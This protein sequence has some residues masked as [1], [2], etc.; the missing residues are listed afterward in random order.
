MGFC[1]FHNLSRGGHYPYS[2][3]LLLPFRLR[4]FCSV[5][6][7]Q[8]TVGRASLRRR[9]TGLTAR[10]YRGK[11]PFHRPTLRVLCSVCRR[12]C[13]HCC[14][15]AALSSR[16]KVRSGLGSLVFVPAEQADAN[17][18]QSVL[19]RGGLL[20]PLPSLD[21]DFLRVVVQLSD[22]KGGK[23]PTLPG[24]VHVYI[25]V[26]MMSS[27]GSRPP[28]STDKAPTAT[29]CIHHSSSG[30]FHLSTAYRVCIEHTLLGTL[31]SSGETQPVHPP[32]Y[33]SNPLDTAVQAPE[34]QHTLSDQC[35]SISVRMANYSNAGDYDLVADSGGCCPSC[36]R[37]PDL[38]VH[39]YCIPCA[40]NPSCPRSSSSYSSSYTSSSRH[41]TWSSSS[42]SVPRRAHQETAAGTSRAFER[43]PDSK[44]PS[45]ASKRSG[46]KR[47]SA[48][49]STAKDSSGGAEKHRASKSRAEE[50]K[51]SRKGAAVA[52]RGPK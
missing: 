17:P 8:A 24:S 12:H 6:R 42:A 22:T 36:C 16:P 15:S 14:C 45:Q 49:T 29:T 23:G 38:G 50:T 40:S 26:Y 30:H 5:S 3:T 47:H 25:R 39:D 10:T 43:K 35:E 21:S 18:D 52:G 44:V 31:I 48:E 34:C 32:T 37:A 51:G 9:E 1:P 46:Q 19:Y 2:N 20:C 7:R 33:K 28:N 11:A 13:R 41:N 27:P 4:P